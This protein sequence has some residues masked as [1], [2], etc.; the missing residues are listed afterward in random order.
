MKRVLYVS[1]IALIFTQ[2]FRIIS[3]SE[4]SDEDGGGWKAGIARV[5]ITPEQSAI[6]TTPWNVNIQS[7]ILEEMTRQAEKVGVKKD[8]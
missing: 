7:A 3:A 6:F 2:L 4:V 1:V 8:K 5:V